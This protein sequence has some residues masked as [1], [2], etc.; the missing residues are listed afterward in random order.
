MKQVQEPDFLKEKTSDTT[1]PRIT[2]ANLFLIL[3]VVIFV[4]VIAVQLFSQ[5]QIQPA[6]GDRAPNFEVTTYDGVTYNLRDLRGQIVVLNLWA[7]WCAPCHVEAPDFQ[8]IYEDYQA[9]GVLIIGVN[10][11]DIDSEALAFIDFYGLTYPNAPDM[12]EVVY[13]TYNAQGLP[14]TFVIDQNGIVAATY[15]GGTSYESLS[16]VLDELIAGSDA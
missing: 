16:A 9:D 3:A 2:S 7:D 13:E 1:S 11:L 4:S 10:W 12:G 6:P 14:E 15:L 8:Q 5:N